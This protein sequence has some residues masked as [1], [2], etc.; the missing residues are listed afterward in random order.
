MTAP[1]AV[2]DVQV[3]RYLN[4]ITNSFD[5]STRIE[6]GA[7]GQ[8]EHG[9]RGP[10]ISQIRLAPLS[11]ETSPI[12]RVK[13]DGDWL[14]GVNMTASSAAI[15]FVPD[16]GGSVGGGNVTIPSFKISLTGDVKPT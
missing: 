5:D 6:R 4:E 7:L 11:P 12:H 13:V 8:P 14:Y 9:A 16:G 3:L 1:L 10:L 15:Y 2:H